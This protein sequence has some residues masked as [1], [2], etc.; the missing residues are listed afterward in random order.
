MKPEPGYTESAKQAGVNGTVVLRAVFASDGKV[1]HI[2]VLTGLP[3][4]LIEA[5]ISAARKITFI[6]ARNYGRPVSMFIQLEYH[7]NLY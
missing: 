5:A 7:F 2:L 1:R 3:N 4:G 6:P